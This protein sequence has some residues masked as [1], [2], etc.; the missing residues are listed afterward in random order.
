MAQVGDMVSP[1]NL[2]MV[3]EISHVHVGATKLI[4]MSP[5]QIFSDSA[6]APTDSPSP[7]VQR[8]S[9]KQSDDDIDI[10]KSYPKKQRAPKATIEALEDLTV[11][12]HKAWKL[13]IGKIEE[14]VKHFS[15]RG[16]V[17]GL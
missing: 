5:A 7:T 9:L 15:S 6:S 1:P 3:Y 4:C 12:Q 13:A 17:I 10:L 11:D 14:L 16:E 8:Q 2:Q